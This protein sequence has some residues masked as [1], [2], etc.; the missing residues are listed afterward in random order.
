MR[1]ELM[2][3][4]QTREAIEKN[5]PVILPLGVLEYHG[6]HLPLGVDTLVVEK[7]LERLE[8]EIDFVLMPTFYYGASSYAV[9]P[10]DNG[11]GTVNIETE[12]LTKFGLSLFRDLLRTGFR[13]VKAFIWH[14]SE[15]FAAG[16]PTDLSFK[17]AARQAIFEYL[18]KERGE[19]W[20]GSEKM[21]GYY[22]EHDAGSDPFNWVQIHALLDAEGFKK[23]PLDHA[24][25][26][27]TSLMLATLPETVKM[28]KLDPTLWYCRTAKDASAEFGEK[29]MAL[30]LD[31]LREVLKK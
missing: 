10:P 28:D 23:N 12:I 9:A 25:K 15:N 14:Q 21:Q 24:G 30:I 8:G 11:C 31:H 3:A 19:G 1:Y 7:A 27:E 26:V 6:E 4:G 29:Y 16:M 2:R 18:E 17:L 22:S 20:W 5:W 13:N